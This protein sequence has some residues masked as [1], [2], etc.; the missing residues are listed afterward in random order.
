MAIS[1]LCET[2]TAYYNEVALAL[3]EPSFEP[4]TDLK[5]NAPIGAYALCAVA[6]QI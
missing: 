2:L 6:V 1:N 3:L 5:V 4:G